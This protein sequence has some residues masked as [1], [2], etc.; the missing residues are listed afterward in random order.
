MGSRIVSSGSY[1]PARCLTNADLK[2]VVDTS[3]EWIVRRTGIRTRYHLA[4]G[5]EPAVMGIEAGKRA[6]AQSDASPESVD[7][8]IAA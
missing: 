1:L 5:E 4:E 6:L 3:D 2:K 7:L 8:L